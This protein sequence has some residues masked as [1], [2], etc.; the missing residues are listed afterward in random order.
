M[1][2]VERRSEVFRARAT[3]SVRAKLDALLALERLRDPRVVPFFLEVLDNRREPAEVRVHI[4]RR[5]RHGDPVPDYRPAI[6]DAILRVLAERPIQDLRLEAALA[7]AH[8]I[9]VDGV[10]SELGRRAL[11]PDEPIDLRYSAFTS[12]QQ[13]GATPETVALLQRLSTDETLGRSAR[14]F[15]SMWRRPRPI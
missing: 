11:D 9:D 10:V 14:S 15:L 5:L 3:A 1:D 8:F 2:E 6:A 12:L 4:L 13:A 7:L